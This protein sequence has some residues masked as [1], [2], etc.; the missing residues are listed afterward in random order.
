MLPFNTSAFSNLLGATDRAAQRKAVVAP[1]D[2]FDAKAEDVIQHI[3]QF[4]Q[5]CEETG[6]IEDFAFIESENSPPS[7][8]DMTDP[9]QKAAWLADP[10]RYN[11][12]N[13]LIDSSKADMTK[14]QAAHDTI[15]SNLK[16]FSSPPDPVKMPLA[17]K[18]L[19]SFQNRQWIYVL[20]M[21]VWSANMKTIMLRYQELHDQ[22]GVVL[23]YCFLHHFAGTTVENLIEA[24][25]A[26][27]ETKI[28]LCLF[29]DNVLEYTNAIRLPIRRLIK[30]NET[31]SFQHFL[32]VFHGC[33]EASNEE[34]RAFIIAL[35]A[36]YRAGGHA[37]S[38]TMLELLDK[39]DAEYNRINN[40]GR[41]TKREDPQ[42]LAL[43]ATISTLQSQ[44]STL[45]GQ[46][47]SLQALIAKTISSTNANT[48]TPTVTKLQKPPPK[49]PNDPEIIEFK[50]YTWKW[51]DKCFDGTWNRTHVTS[52]HVA[53]VGKRHRRRE[54][55]PSDNKNAPAAPVPQANIAQAPPPDDTLSPPPTA[56][57]N[58][59]TVSSI[60]DFI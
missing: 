28:Q 5:R 22:D 57:A 23:W 36:E 43:T 6:I 31:P 20:L 60:L 41:W 1:F 19:I 59:A 3:A 17:S 50:G 7:T 29:Q 45:K 54:P 13:L 14:I 26:L 9:T 53:G 52:E 18:Q 24:Y 47:G 33:M 56:H 34:F 30:A 37:K 58:I 38:L 55:P 48:P 46:Y 25:S 44:L 8:I 12:G 16:K 40:L 35:Y 39:L 49:H 10:K 15:R 2:E 42:V 21:A 11:Y 4:T 51:C 32:T 27:S